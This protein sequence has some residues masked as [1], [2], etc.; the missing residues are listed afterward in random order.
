M[1]AERANVHRQIRAMAKENAVRKCLQVPM[2]DLKV[3]FVLTN[4]SKFVLPGKT[5]TKTF[6]LY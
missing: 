6:I 4:E 1:E 5:L 3:V 2:S